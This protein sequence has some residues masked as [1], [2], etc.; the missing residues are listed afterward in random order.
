MAAIAPMMAAA[1][2]LS[3]RKA[4]NLR[5]RDNRAEEMAFGRMGGR[6][7]GNLREKAM[8]MAGKSGWYNKTR[9]RRIQ[10]GQSIADIASN[11]KANKPIEHMRKTQPG[12]RIDMTES[13]GRNRIDYSDNASDVYQGFSSN[14]ID[15]GLLS[16]RFHSGDMN[17]INRRRRVQPKQMGGGERLSFR[18]T[19][20]N[21][22]TYGIGQGFNR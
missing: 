14:M 16:R 1:G 15:R 17:M 3:H 21:K 18:N 10:P 11:V 6:F 13:I 2:I 7:K 9:H 4:E 22:G 8:D 19:Q 12:P 5:S 20:P